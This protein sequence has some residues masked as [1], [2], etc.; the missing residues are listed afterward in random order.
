MRV[1]TETT[2]D[3]L[4]R[5][6]VLK[7]LIC[8]NEGLTELKIPTECTK[9]HCQDNELTELYLH[10]EIIMLSCQRNKIKELILPD[11]M[12]NLVCDKEL[13]DYDTCKVDSVKIVY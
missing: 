3:S 9:A 5:R 2:T 13:F 10:D 4:L 11:S 1:N 8:T 12:K 6:I 7:R